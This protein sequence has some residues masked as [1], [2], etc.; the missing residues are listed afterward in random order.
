MRIRRSERLREAANKIDLFLSSSE[1]H[2]SRHRLALTTIDVKHKNSANPTTVGRREFDVPVRF[3]EM[4]DVASGSEFH[5]LQDLEAHGERK[6]NF[7]ATYVSAK[8]FLKQIR[9]AREKH[10]V[11]Y[12][13]GE[14]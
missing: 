9:G 11:V 7:T 3:G 14:M 8:E 10:I 6:D 1:K 12:V 13:H 4:D 2:R 5:F